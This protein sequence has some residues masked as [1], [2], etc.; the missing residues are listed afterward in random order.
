MVLIKLQYDDWLD[1]PMQG[2]VDWAH[3]PRRPAWWQGADGIWH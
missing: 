1:D 3:R 2:G